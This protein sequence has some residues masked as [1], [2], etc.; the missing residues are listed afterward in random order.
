MKYRRPELSASDITATA[1]L[2]LTARGFNVWRQTIS[3]MRRKNITKH[4]VSDIIGFNRSTGKFVGCEIKKKGDVLSTDQIEFLTQVHAAG[5]V[6]LLAV[7]E[8][9]D[10]VLKEFSTIITNKT[11]QHDTVGNRTKKDTGN[12]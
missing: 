10:V 4:G 12:P 11:K 7:E 8:N 2:I 5:G 9:G 3:K 6:A 1:K